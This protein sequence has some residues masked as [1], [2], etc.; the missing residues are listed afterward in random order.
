MST[1]ASCSQVQAALSES[2]S[3]WVEGITGVKASYGEF[4]KGT[5]SVEV[6]ASG[7]DP[8]VTRYRSGGGI[9]CWSYEV[10]LKT[11]GATESQRIDGIAVLG[12]VQ[13]AI[14]ARSF[15][16]ADVAFVSHEVTNAPHL[17]AEEAGANSVYQ[18][19][20]SIMYY[21]R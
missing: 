20:A 14:A 19:T 5:P 4:S 10:Y 21:A 12:L 18:M 11:S 3:R 9:Y 1:G 7:G 17:Y 8:L 6:V 13:A 2:V 16:G 15:P